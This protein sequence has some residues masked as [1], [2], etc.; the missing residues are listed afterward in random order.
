METHRLIPHPDTPPE[1]VEAVEVAFAAER[2]GR[3]RLAWDVRGRGGLVLPAQAEPARGDDLW[4]TTCFELFLAPD[5]A[6]ACFEFNFSPSTRWAAYRFQRYRD[7]RA[8]LLLPVEPVPQRKGGSGR[9]LEVDLDLSGLSDL[10]MRMGLSA[11][12]EE[13]GGRLSY[14]SLAHPP[15]T[16]DFHDRD[17]FTLRLPAARR[18]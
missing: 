6:D 1:G 10:P 11:V 4:Q 2:G 7:G 14:W 5:G 16:P 18:A 3:L 15:E 9:I 8:D 12:I 17:C 13:Q